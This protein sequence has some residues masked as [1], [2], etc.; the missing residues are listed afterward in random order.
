[1]KNTRKHKIG[2]PVRRK[3]IV[4]KRRKALLTQATAMGIPTWAVLGLTHRAGRIVGE[5]RKRGKLRRYHAKKN[6]ARPEIFTAVAVGHDGRILGC[7]ESTNPKS[8]MASADAAGIS[9]STH[10]TVSGET[11]SDG[12]RHGKG[13]GRVVFQREG[14]QWRGM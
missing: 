14:G 13:R 2:S 10:V 7:W 1:M 5:A 3:K 12:T 9:K 8:A 6:D 4:I 11:T